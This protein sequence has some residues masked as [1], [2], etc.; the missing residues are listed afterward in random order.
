MRPTVLDRVAK[1]SQRRQPGCAAIGDRGPSAPG[2]Q[3]ASRDPG[4]TAPASGS[5]RRQPGCAAIGPRAVRA[6]MARRESRHWRYRSCERLATPPAGMRRHRAA[7][8]PR[9]DGK[10]RVATLEVPLLRAA[11][12][13]ASR[14]RRFAARHR[15]RGRGRGGQRPSAL[16]GDGSSDLTVGRDDDDRATDRLGLDQLSDQVVGDH[17]RRAEPHSD[18]ARRDAPVAGWPGRPRRT[19][20]SSPSPCPPTSALTPWTSRAR[21]WSSGSVGQAAFDTL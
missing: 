4:G 11:R 8:R 5:Q 9:P 12:N 3:G 20:P 2:W 21:C 19:R 7:G 14:M 13:A 10:A 18:A 16:L 1:G 15:G 6:R 17:A